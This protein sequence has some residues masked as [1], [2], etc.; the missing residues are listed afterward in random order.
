VDTVV[1]ALKAEAQLLLKAENAHF[2]DSI[3]N[4]GRLWETERG[5]ICIT[6]VGPVNTRKSLNAYLRQYHPDRLINLG[7]AGNLGL[8]I[9]PLTQI[10]PHRIIDVNSGYLFYQEAV[11]TRYSLLTTDKPVT[12]KSESLSLQQKF[13]ESFVDMEA[14][15]MVFCAMAYHIPWIVWKTIS[16][17]AGC[18]TVSDYK[19]R[20]PQ[21]AEA[22]ASKAGEIWK[23]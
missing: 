16:D 4:M 11:E 23:R 8:P 22:I 10:Q 3:G 9:K 17:N 20:L 7:A 13:G 5:H 21:I 12:T 2:K 1:I 15:Q 18:H 6:G 19:S 14:A